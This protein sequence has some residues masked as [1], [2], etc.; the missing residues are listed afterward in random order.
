M[1]P[2]AVVAATRQP[3]PLGRAGLKPS[4]VIE[5]SRRYNAEGKLKLKLSLGGVRVERCG[6]C[7]AQF[8]AGEVGI[9]L[10]CK[11]P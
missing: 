9:I 4:P 3:D 2:S 7:L 1:G 10:R 11:H 6:I 8:T 5:E